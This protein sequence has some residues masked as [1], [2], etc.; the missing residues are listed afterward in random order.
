MCRAETL[1]TSGDEVKRG[2]LVQ[3]VHPP[4]LASRVVTTLRTT[5][6]TAERDRLRDMMTELW[7]I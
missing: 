1:T 7:K 4:R 3:L 5:A 2:Q 6:S